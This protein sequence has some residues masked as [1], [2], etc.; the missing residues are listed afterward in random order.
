VAAVKPLHS[1]LPKGYVAI[2]R[3]E[4]DDSEEFNFLGNGLEALH[5]AVKLA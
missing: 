2:R 3:G 4:E 1:S 5:L